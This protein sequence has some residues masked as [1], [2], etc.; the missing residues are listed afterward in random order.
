RGDGFVDSERFGYITASYEL[1]KGYSDTLLS[2]GC[3][4]YIAKED[5]EDASYY[6]VVISSSDSMAK[7]L[8]EVVES[9]DKRYKK[10]LTFCNRSK[11]RLNDRDVM[12]LNII[13]QTY[14]LLKNLRIADGY[15]VNSIKKKQN[16]HV[17]KVNH[18]LNLIEKH[19]N[20]ISL[21]MH[22][23]I[24]RRKLNI[25]L[26]ELSS[27]YGC[28]TASIRN[29]EKRNDPKYL[30]ILKKRAQNKLQRC[31]QLL[32]D[33]KKFTTSDLRLVTVKSIKKIPNKDIK[34][35]YDVTVEPNHT[36]ISE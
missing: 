31:K 14:S 15:F 6:K 19:L 35:V 27:A 12:P 25:T 4:N 18:Y 21:D 5:R 26:K 17:K 34:W 32:L 3:W 20:N 33:L 2:I 22:S 29:L 10:I 11:N 13:K 24:L 36:F 16:A 1:A 9:C 30:K 8:Q 23:Q 7:F 28:C